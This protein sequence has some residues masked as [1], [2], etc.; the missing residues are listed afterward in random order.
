MN[1]RRWVHDFAS[2]FF[3][4]RVLAV[5]VDHAMNE[6][7]LESRSAI[8]H[9]GGD[10]GHLQRRGENVALPDRDVSGMSIR[11]A[12]ARMRV[13]QPLGA[14]KDSLAFARNRDARLLAE[15]EGLTDGHDLVDAGS[16]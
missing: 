16:V 11:P 7:G 9:G 12:L 2:E 8:R 4:A 3:L 1:L 10:H 15:A 6:M 5:F 14:R 13:T